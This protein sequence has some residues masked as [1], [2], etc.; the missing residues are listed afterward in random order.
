MRTLHI[1]RVIE[2]TVN[3]AWIYFI[4]SFENISI[5]VAIQ[6]DKMYEYD[7]ATIISSKNEET[8]K[9]GVSF[10]RVSFYPANL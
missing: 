1:S 8:E 6:T 4:F 9:K 2:N 3:S 10:I 7:C 5:D